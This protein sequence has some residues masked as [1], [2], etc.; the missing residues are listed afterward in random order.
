PGGS[1]SPAA[2]TGASAAPS[3]ASGAPSAAPSAQPSNTPAAGN[4]APGTPVP[5]KDGA[6]P[7]GYRTVHDASGFSIVLPDWMADMGRA[8]DATSRNFEGNGL[9][10]MVD[11]T[12]G[13]GDSALADWQDSERTQNW[14][15]Y[16]RIQLKG[17]TYRDWTN[18]AD[19]EWT[20][21]SS[22]TNHS[23]NRGFVTGNGKY[24]YA[25]YWTSTDADWNSAANTAARTIAF[26]TFQPAP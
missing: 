21:G 18:A 1:G 9:K 10:L 6:V 8:Y 11:W 24:G 7:A 17:I 20:Y 23:L 5:G 12:V 16:K 15:N 25:L 26:A 22:T 14:A 19:W 13:A 3:A 4:P 2:G